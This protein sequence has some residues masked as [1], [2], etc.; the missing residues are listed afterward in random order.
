MMDIRAT[1]RARLDAAVGSAHVLTAPADV[2]PFLTDWRGRYQG[3]ALAVVRPG[4][5]D[6]VA[7]V[8]RACAE[9]RVAIV[10]QGGNTGQCGGATPDATGDAVVLSLN[11]LNHI[12]AVDPDNATLT[13]EAGVPLVAVQ[14]AAADAGLQFP[15]SLAAEGSCTIGGNL[16]TN[17][18]GTAVLR[19][20]N[21]REL[22]LGIEVVLADGRVWNGL[23]GL[24]KDNTGYDLK[25]LFIG[26]EG[27]LGIVTAAVLKLFPAP[28]TRVRKSSPKVFS[29]R[30][31]LIASEVARQPKQQMMNA[32]TTRLLKARLPPCPTPL[33]LSPSSSCWTHNSVAI[34]PMITRTQ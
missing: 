30:S 33:I 19:F 13:A 21:T 7:A 5:T 1:L 16:S 32:T 9:D 15:L 17:A 8:V 25:Q 23:R 2:A 31:Q 26:A 14:Q 24:R 29:L 27:T 12:R 18:G 6:Q 10:P 34:E 28:R 3:R 11:R 4:T 22:V 20:G